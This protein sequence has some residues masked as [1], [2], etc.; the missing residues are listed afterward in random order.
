MIR[1]VGRPRLHDEQT[2][3]ALL[4]ASTSLIAESGTGVLTVRSVA[5]RAGTTTR[6]VYA[7]CGSKEGLVEALAERAFSL[8]IEQ[9]D[10]VPLTTDPGEDLV[11][12]GVLGYR[13]F[14]LE[15]PDLFRFVFSAAPPGTRIESESSAPRA[16]AYERLT[17]RVERALAAGLCG[18]HAV[19]EVALLWDA[20][21]YGLAM[22]ELCGSIDPSQAGRLWT[23][24]LHALLVGL[25]TPPT[26]VP[27][28][29]SR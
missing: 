2:R 21:C 20:M 24:A 23:V 17:L 26:S 16:N 3:E 22:R 18:D 4:V 9:V 28:P 8:L 1:S 29:S 5:D 19:D 25:A 12:A 11:R 7:V 15:Q 6:A 14:A 10:K 27:G 13:T